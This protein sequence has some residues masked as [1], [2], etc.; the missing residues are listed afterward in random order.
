MTWLVVGLGNPGPTYATTRHNVGCFVS[1][2]LSRRMGSSFAV[3]KA[4]RAEIV[5]GRLA[6]ERTILGRSRGYMNVSGGPVSAIMK[7]FSVDLEHLIVIH[8][9][10]DLPVGSLRLKVGGGDNGHNGL[11]SIRQS[12]GTGDFHRVRIGVGRPMGRQAVH[13]FVL[14]PFAAAE[15]TEI[16]IVTQDAADAVES[17]IRH[18]LSRTQSDFNS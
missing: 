13:D 12:L 9:E 10:L 5:S 1:D 8:D 18:G 2:E 16:E 3:H 17:L 15:R 4:T 14:K 11:R 7:Y 6:D